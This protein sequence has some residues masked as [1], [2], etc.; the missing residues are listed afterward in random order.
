VRLLIAL[1]SAAALVADHSGGGVPKNTLTRATVDATLARVSERVPL[2]AFGSICDGVHHPLSER[3]GTL[4]EAQ[5]VYPTATS[6]DG[7]I[8]TAALA[9][10]LAY[11]DG[12][13]KRGRKTARPGWIGQGT[14]LVDRTLYL[15]LGVDIQ[16]AGRS[17]TTARGGTD[18]QRTP[19]MTGDIFR[20]MPFTDKSNRVQ[21][22]DGKLADFR[23]INTDPTATV[24]NGI[25]LVD[26]A[27]APVRAQNNTVFEDLI[28][29]G[30]PENG[31]RL[32]IGGL[33]TYF[34]RVELFQNKLNGVYWS[35]RADAV[36]LSGISGDSNGESVLRFVNLDPDSST[37]MIEALKSEENENETFS[38]H[39]RNTPVL[40]ESNRPSASFV[41]NGISHIRAGFR[42]AGA[43]QP[44][45]SAIVYV[46]SDRP[47]V[48]FQGVRIRVP[49]SA[50]GPGPFSFEG[51]SL[52]PEILY[53]YQKTHGALD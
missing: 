43:A 33:A 4:A 41:I 14:C 51:R 11:L 20:V 52:S 48:V 5:V 24:G 25:N 27:G 39:G 6:L 15:P 32:P 26:A 29:R 13:T 35:G 50:G 49:P 21:W 19:G 28:V 16:G 53:S 1:A 23:I 45:G 8:D 47:D 10:W 37:V 17:Q 31:I 44:P 3:Y 9:T 36:L 7:E 30:M 2:S 18:L 12:T 40:I 22:W 38:I 46:G 34:S 42:R